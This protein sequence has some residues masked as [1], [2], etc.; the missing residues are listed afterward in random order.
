MARLVKDLQYYKFGFY[1]FLKNLRLFEPFLILFFID[2]GLSYLQIGILYG[3]R[4]IARNI[5]EI[6]A[7]VI[8]DATGRRRSMITSFTAYI[9][10]FLM[11][12]FAGSYTLFFAAMFLFAVG[13]AFRTGTHKAMIFD[14]LKLKGREEQKADYYGHTRAFSQFG[15]AISS[16]L[17]AALVF[18][19]G[20]YRYIFLITVVPYIID[21]FLLAS[22]PA[23][24][25]G[26]TAKTQIKFGKRFKTVAG[27]FFTAVKNFRQVKTMLS[28]SWYSGYYKVV[29]DFIQPIIAGFALAIPF[30]NP[31]NDEKKTAVTI[32]VVYFFIYLLTSWSSK[33]TKHISAL[34][35]TGENALNKLMTAGFIT[36][37]AAS[38]VYYLGFAGLSVLLMLPVFMIENVRKPI[39]VSV[40]ADLTNQGVL[41]SVLSVQSQLQTLTVVI[42]APVLG[43]FAD[44][45]GL[46]K[47]MMITTFLMLLPAILLRIKSD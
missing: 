40:I 10:S 23:V 7:G 11:F 19:T 35:T 15:S 3:F 34:F 6:P 32:G 30:L 17:S 45:Y 43:F 24:L 25:D 18:F 42:A 36:G 2:A 29:K 8:A 26:H 22:Y 27:E 12:F 28:I 20:N 9:F 14:Y 4:E 13:D 44:R 38:A 37:L 16:L 33:N 46:G 1:G 47:G 31:L 5:M 39:G 41:A 21:L